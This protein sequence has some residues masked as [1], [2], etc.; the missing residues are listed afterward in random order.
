MENN[1]ES[2]SSFKQ[3]SGKPGKENKPDI[4]GQKLITYTNYEESEKEL[5]SKILKITLM[6]NDQYPELS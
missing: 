1:S 2:K 3:T 6:I 4:S 5:N